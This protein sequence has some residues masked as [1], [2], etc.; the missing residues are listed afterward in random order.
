MAATEVFASVLYIS[1]GA[2]SKITLKPEPSSRRSEWMNTPWA[3]P[4][5]S[6]PATNLLVS[7][8]VPQKGTKKPALSEGSG[9]AGMPTAPPRRTSLMTLRMP[10]LVDGAT[11]LPSCTRCFC[12]SSSTAFSFGGR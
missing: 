11:R 4:P 8:W 5:A 10:S 12:S 1:S 2:A 7:A 3:F 6:I 9:S